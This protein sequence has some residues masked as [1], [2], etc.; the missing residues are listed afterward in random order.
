MNLTAYAKFSA[1]NLPD[2]WDPLN[3]GTGEIVKTLH[4]SIGWNNVLLTLTPEYYHY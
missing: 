3:L 2:L 1:N 4:S